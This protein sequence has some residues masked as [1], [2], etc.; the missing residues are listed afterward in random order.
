MVMRFKEA[1]WIASFRRM[2]FNLSF[3]GLEVKMDLRYI[4][5]FICSTQWDIILS[6]K[7]FCA[8]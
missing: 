6:V 4:W 5:L 2:V 7:A 1:A 3:A 8:A